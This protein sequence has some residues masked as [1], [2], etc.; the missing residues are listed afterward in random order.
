[1]TAGHLLGYLQRDPNGAVGRGKLLSY[2]LP[3]F[4]GQVGIEAGYDDCLHGQAGTKSVLVNNLGYRQTETTWSP[5]GAG[6]NVVLTLDLHVQ[7]AA[8][9]ALQ[10]SGP[11]TRG[12]A[13]VMDVE[14]GDIL[15]LAS[16]PQLDPNVFIQ[17]AT[18][19]E[20]ARLADRKLR[21]QINRAT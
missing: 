20:A 8:E 11:E 5:A 6:T 14:S 15:A 2:S 1:S 18:T 4:R 12:A 3:D 10:M 13:V 7:Q 17:G 21:V 19:S 16:S 9:H